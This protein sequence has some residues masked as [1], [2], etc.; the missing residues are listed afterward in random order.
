MGWANDCMKQKYAQDV[1]DL[2]HK[3]NGWHFRALHTFEDQLKDFQ[4]EDM[5]M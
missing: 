2:S 3:A 4:I 1:K 5:A